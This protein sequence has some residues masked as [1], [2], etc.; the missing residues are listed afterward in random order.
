VSAP[1]TGR[2]RAI[3]SAFGRSLKRLREA[4]GLTR[5]HLECKAGISRGMLSRIETGARGCGL[6]VAH[7][8][9][10]ALGTTVDAMITEAD[11]GAGGDP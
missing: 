5:E 1:K 9:A 7:A 3:E 10:T 8:L 6:P 4:C 2:D 11:L